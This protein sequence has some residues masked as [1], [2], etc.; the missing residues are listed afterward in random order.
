MNGKKLMYI[1]LIAILVIS[2]LTMSTAVASADDRRYQQIHFDPGLP[3]FGNA[4]THDNSIL[5][6]NNSFILT[7]IEWRYE[8]VY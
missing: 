4:G 8:Y 3:L 2:I 6:T 1:G 5:T 7:T